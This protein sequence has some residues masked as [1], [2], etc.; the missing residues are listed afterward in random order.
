MG[1][2]GER[3]GEGWL[4]LS[5]TL[6]CAYKVD[7]AAEVREVVDT[8]A[9]SSWIIIVIWVPRIVLKGGLNELDG[10]CFG[11]TRAFLARISHLR[12]TSFSL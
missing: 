10:A 5:G 3:G 4:T 12:F 8:M 11:S 7:G 2:A 9:R 1:G 6:L